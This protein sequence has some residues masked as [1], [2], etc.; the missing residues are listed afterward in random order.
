MS[1]QQISSDTQSG[2]ISALLIRTI[3]CSTLAPPLRTRHGAA[4]RVIWA[5]LSGFDVWRICLNSP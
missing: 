1:E 2:Q 5:V 3:Q 4:L